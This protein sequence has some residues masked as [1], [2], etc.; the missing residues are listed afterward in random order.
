M[1]NT[2]KG[3]WTQF[4]LS[5]IL[6]NSLGLLGLSASTKLV[7]LYLCDCYNPN[8]QTVYPL[9]QT[10][11][12]RLGVSLS[13]VKRA[14]K[15]L[16][17]EGLVVYETKNSNLYRFSPKF[18]GLFEQE[19]QDDPQGGGKNF[20]PPKM[21]PSRVQDDTQCGSKMTPLMYKQK[22]ENKNEQGAGPRSKIQQNCSR[23]GEW[24]KFGYRYRETNRP[25][26]GVSYKKYTPE[27]VQKGSPLDFG[28]KEARE[29]LQNLPPFLQGSKFAVAL[30]EKWSFLNQF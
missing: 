19:Y 5:K 16:S 1:N 30:R 29:Y 12:D 22:N 23:G 18:F 28:E 15:E 6:L 3:A 10:I 26:G 20:Y 24:G 13:S 27:R 21:T 17:G 9:Q 14:I 4:R 8:N 2:Q 7:L 25:Q 11:S